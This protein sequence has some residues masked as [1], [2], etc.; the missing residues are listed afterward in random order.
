MGDYLHILI[1][2]NE[3]FPNGG[4]ATNRFKGYAQ[5]LVKLG[6]E[7]SV[8][9]WSSSGLMIEGNS[10]SGSYE[11]IKYEYSFTHVSHNKVIRRFYKLIQIVT[12][13]IHT[14][15]FLRRHDIDCVLLVSNDPMMM[16]MGYMLSKLHNVKYIQEKSEYPFVLMKARNALQRIYATMYC[17]YLY[18]IFDG[19]II[20]TKT[21][22]DYFSTVCSKDAVLFHMPMTVD[23]SRFTSSRQ[24]KNKWITYCGSFGGTKDGV[25][26]LLMAYS[27][28][29][30]EYPGWKLVLVGKASQ[31]EEARLKKLVSLNGLSDKV[32][33]TGHLD[34]SEVP[35]ILSESSILVLSRPDSIQA[36]YGFP[37]KL[38]EYL[39]TA[40]PVV[41]T[42]VGEIKD[43]L[44]NGVS[45]MI[46]KPGNIAELAD[47]IQFLIND[48]DQANEI[49]LRGREI[50]EKCFDIKVQAG[51][52]AE[53]LEGLIG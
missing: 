17:K 27:I 21:L 36:Q 12:G 49:G 28:V 13:T 43:Y 15:G 1:I 22:C 25:D 26:H 5:E 39:A 47:K 35:K 23:L 34:Y 37:S 44:E 50:A 20:M 32:K 31:P 51:R 45:A 9:I 2:T 53:Y 6:S 4:A 18:R 40:N 19:M 46:A 48:P 10:S 11:G 38:G 42:D 14:N 16:I 8:I 24:A 30:K 7:V 33:W 52:L 41:V 3:P 29:A